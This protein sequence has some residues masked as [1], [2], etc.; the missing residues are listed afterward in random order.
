MRL[1]VFEA[2]V[3]SD[4]SGT[5]GSFLLFDQ[6]PGD[7]G[8]QRFDLRA[9]AFDIVHQRNVNGAQLAIAIDFSVLVVH[10]GTSL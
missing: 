10:G 2:T 3:F 8:A 5:H 1:G 9:Q 4:A 6:M 7:A